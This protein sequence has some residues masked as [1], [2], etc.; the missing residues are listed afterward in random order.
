MV[1]TTSDPEPFVSKMRDLKP[2]GGA[3]LYDAIYM[4]C[5]NRVAAAGRAV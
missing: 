1:N 4:A 2:G 5:T 3:A